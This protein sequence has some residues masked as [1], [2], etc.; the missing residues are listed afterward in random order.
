MKSFFKNKKGN[1]VLDGL[2]LVVSLFALSI[3][4]ILGWFVWGS[5]EPG[6]RGEITTTEGNESLN[7]I[8]NNYVNIFDGLFLFIFIGL[9][10]AALVASF[11]I[12]S[13]PIFFAISII[14]MIGVC[15]ASIFVGNGYEEI[16]NDTEFDGLTP[17]FPMTHYIMSHL[18]I[19]VIVVSMSIMLVLYAKTRS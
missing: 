3:V 6:L 5:L 16:M 2:A 19:V 10:I 12:D 11:M 15:I 18:L 14:L 7:I 9:W 1:A 13:H 8:D 4:F 17:Q